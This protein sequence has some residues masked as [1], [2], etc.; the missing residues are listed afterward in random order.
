MR[1]FSAFIHQGLA[2]DCVT[3][4]P[5]GGNCWFCGTPYEK[6]GVMVGVLEEW[7]CPK[8]DEHPPP[9]QNDKIA[10]AKVL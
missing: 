1:T 9:N 6:T 3:N 5:S 8:A 2:F 7:R 4:K 10:S